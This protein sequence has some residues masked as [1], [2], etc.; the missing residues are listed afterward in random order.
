[1]RNKMRLRGVSF[2]VETGRTRPPR[3]PRFGV[4][5]PADSTPAVVLRSREEV[6]LGFR[7]QELRM[8]L[9]GVPVEFTAATRS[10]GRFPFGHPVLVVS[11]SVSEY[12]PWPGELAGLDFLP[13]VAAASDRQWIDRMLVMRDHPESRALAR[14]YQARFAMRWSKSGVSVIDLETD[15]EVTR[16]LMRGRALQQRSCPLIPGAIPGE[17]CKMYGGPW[18]PR[19]MVASGYWMDRR[20]LYTSELGCD[21]VCSPASTRRQDHLPTRYYTWLWQSEIDQRWDELVE[22][23]KAS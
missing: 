7:T 5:T 3:Q 1:M 13:A 12:L 22:H 23:A 21:Q 14:T 10:D 4:I 19:S 17:R 20:F 11:T 9:D 8:N 15:D 16:Y 2:P 18:L 6:V